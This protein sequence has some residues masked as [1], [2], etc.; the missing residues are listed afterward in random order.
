MLLAADLSAHIA[1]EAVAA[2]E[3]DERGGSKGLFVCFRRMGASR[4]RPLL[5]IKGPDGRTA[6]D[7]EERAAMLQLS[8][9]QLTRGSVE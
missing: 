5:T 6:A 7:A 2:A 1:E 8:F 3:A 9:A 4:P